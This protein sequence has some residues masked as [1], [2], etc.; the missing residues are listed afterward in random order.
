MREHNDNVN[1]LLQYTPEDGPPLRWL[2]T[3]ARYV[4]ARLNGHALVT[5]WLPGGRSLAVD[6]VFAVRNESIVLQGRLEDGKELHVSTQPDAVMLEIRAAPEDAKCAV[7]AFIGLSR[8]PQPL[9]DCTLEKSHK[10][11]DDEEQGHHG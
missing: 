6:Y 9:I 7:F 8:T 3:Q 11:P 5:T 4:R 1:R 2:K 10:D